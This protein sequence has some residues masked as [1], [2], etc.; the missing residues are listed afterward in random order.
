MLKIGQSF[1]I[2]ESQAISS[3]NWSSYGLLAGDNNGNIH[4]W[5]NANENYKLG[6]HSYI[7][8]Q[9]Y[10]DELC[11]VVSIAVFNNI[12]CFCTLYGSFYTMTLPPQDSEPLITISDFKPEK[13][14]E[15]ENA[16]TILAVETGFLIGTITGKV[17]LYTLSNNNNQSAPLQEVQLFDE[18]ICSLASNPYTRGYVAL[19]RSKILFLHKQDLH[20]LASLN[21]TSK[22][23]CSLSLTND[24]Y[25]IV[26]GSRSGS[27]QIV[28][29]I[30]FTECGIIETEKT[31]IN[32]IVPCDFSNRFM[33]VTGNGKVLNFELVD[34][35]DSAPFYPSILYA[36][37]VNSKCT[38]AAVAGN[39][40]LINILTINSNI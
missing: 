29:A 28:D 2:E 23:N 38:K 35:V 16:F 26:I 15:I 27:I 24:G 39:S 10:S 4:F 18:P 6:E 12:C 14:N 20:I 3:L 11:S 5:P 34:K 36:V 7:S 31:S 22:D 32:S 13:V 33:G 17:I 1:T 40:Q 30:T 9:T 8:N 21:T 37:A 25:S 19:S